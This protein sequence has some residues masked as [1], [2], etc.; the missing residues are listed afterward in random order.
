M[1]KL[2]SILI[3]F[4]LLISATSCMITI[5]INT[6]L[7]P[8]D[9]VLRAEA[10]YDD[11]DA[12]D[13]LFTFDQIPFL[14]TD[15]MRSEITKI[16]FQP[17]LKGVPDMVYDLSEKGDQSVIMWNDNGTV[18][19]AADGAIMANPNSSSLFEDMSNLKS[20]DLYGLNTSL[21][22][23]MSSMFSGCESLTSID[24]S[25]FETGSVTDMSN[26]F[27][28][29]ES[30]TKLDV[31]SF[32]T[33]NVADMTFM[34]AF[35]S[36]IKKLDLSNFNTSNVT[37]MVGMFST[38]TALESLDLS[39]FDLHNVTALDDFFEYCFK[40]SDINCELDVP[41]GYT[42]NKLIRGTK[43]KRQE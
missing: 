4:G 35:C 16:I 18:T 42:F 2:A 43:I 17:N 23:N 40:L 32:D 27:M 8:T 6:P 34:F 12:L 14:G 33:K 22:T 20:I 36:G 7:E 1:K 19:I 26:M 5:N 13:Y 38:C 25:R 21:A 37:R 11:I 15:V 9:N 31:S 24:L 39:S 41:E 30:L 3:I 10:V 28:S 29:C